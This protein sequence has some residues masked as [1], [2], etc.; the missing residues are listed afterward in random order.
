MWHMPDS[1]PLQDDCQLDALVPQDPNLSSTFRGIK[2]AQSHQQQQGEI[3]G[4]ALRG[5]VPYSA[6]FAG[7][8]GREALGLRSRRRQLRGR[9]GPTSRDHRPGSSLPGSSLDD[10]SRAIITTHK[11]LQEE[12]SDQMLTLAGQMKA[13]SLAMEEKVK[14][15]NK[16]TRCCHLME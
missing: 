9:H 7:G 11:N 1:L 6:A 2:P 12:L 3:E 4:G 13:N 5:Y 10:A 14:S 8:Q 15:S 16:V